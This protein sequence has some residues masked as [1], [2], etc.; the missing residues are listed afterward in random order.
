MRFNNIKLPEEIRIAH[1]QDR[2]VVFAGAGLSVPPPSKLPLFNGLVSKICG[3]KPV[4]E[5]R[6]DRILGKMKRAG[7]DVHSAAAGILFGKHTRPTQLHGEILRLFGKPERVRIVTT[8]FDDHFSTKS[9]EIFRLNRPQEYYAP[10]LP[11][12]D[13]FAGIVYLHGSARVDSRALVLTDRDF[14]I[15]YLTRGWAK[16]F[17][18]D[19]FS[20]YTVLFIGYSHNDVTTTYLAR[21]LSQSEVKPRWTMIPSNIKPEGRENWEHLEIKVIEYPVDTTNTSNEHQSLTDF[22]SEWAVHAGES[23]F[24]RAKRIKAIARSL[25]P[26]NET[27][28]EYLS[29]TLNHERLAQELCGNLK[30]PAWVGWLHDNGFFD[31]CFDDDTSNSSNASIDHH[32][33]IASWLCNFVRSRFPLL[34]LNLI[35]TH[36]QRLSPRFCRQLAHSLWTEKS[37]VPDKHFSEW[38]SILLA[39]GREAVPVEHFAYLLLK[40]RLPDH[41]GVALQLFDLLLTPRIRVEKGLDWSDEKQINSPL[42]IKVAYAVEWPCKDNHNISKAW[43]DVFQPHLTVIAEPLAQ[44]IANHFTQAHW[45][46]RGVKSAS[47]QYDPLSFSWSSIAQHDQNRHRLGECLATNVEILRE[48]F[49]HW[50]QTDPPRARMQLDIWWK[51]GIPLLRRFAAFAMSVDHQYSSDDRINWLLDHDLVFQSGMK[52]EVFDVLASAYSTA[53]MSIR[54]RLLQRI[55]RGYREPG[56]KNRR[57]ESIAYEQFNVLVWLRRS[58]PTCELIS[59]S[60]D[61]IRAA[62]P[63]FGE[64]EHPNFDI[65]HYDARVMDPAEGVDID[66]VISEPPEHFLNH[67]IANVSGDARRDLWSIAQNLPAFFKRDKSWGKG[68]V[69]ALSR[70][71]SLGDELWQPVFHAWREAIKTE[72]EWDWILTE[73]EKLPRSYAIYCG[74][75]YLIANGLWAK[76]T[77]LSNSIIDRAAL[78]MDLAWEICSCR[79]EPLDDNYRDWLTAAI[80][81]VGGWIGEFWRHYCGHLRNR[82]GEKWQ[83]IPFALR[84]KIEEAISGTNGV[85]IYA[86][87]A[88]TPWLGYFYTW[89]RDFSVKHLMPLLDWQR[90]SIVAQ[91]T[92][93]VLLDYNRGTSFELEELLIPYYQQFAERVLTMLKDATEKSDQFSSHALQ[94]LGYSL[95]GLATHVIP[96]PVESGFFRDFL[97]L[98]PDNV[99]SALAIGI[100]QQLQRF[101]DVRRKQIWDTWLRRYVDLRR[102]GV[103][104]A[105]SFSEA[106]YMLEWCLYLGPVFAE[107]VDSIAILPQKDVNAFGII[108]TLLKSSVL[109]TFP[110]HCCRLVIAALR[111]EDFPHLHPDLL[112]LHKN[113]KDAIAGTL[114]LQALEELLYLRGW[115]KK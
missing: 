6:E 69:E 30:H 51:S 23:L 110:L 76:D 80:N 102:I 42:P 90:D 101:D 107:A 68:F 5:G 38:V 94:N 88:L 96:N 45:L 115:N 28:S 64:R 100:M 7:T 61:K 89:D 87:I 97:P 35:Q 43:C 111:A 67:I 79:S 65:W 77:V 18:V 46:L 1:E 84:V 12:G 55:D 29:Y 58:A 40:C 60:I 78:H 113:F 36:K 26:E 31:L 106:K 2:L 14:G 54:R 49:L 70:Q 75:A 98:L 62:F 82:S 8:N 19:L 53:S 3:E 81:H 57:P 32:G 105:L 104:V 72:E 9:K 86:R 15:A 56:F 34:L 108:S 17:L 33:V 21:G 16:T 52:K 93:S 10:A 114:E 20:K 103:P 22:F 50:A 11:L 4:Q 112:T 27:I 74:V 83:G 73:I 95:S 24:A 44:I 41:L 99:R 37:K 66:K 13:N 71:T 48:I 85:A 25:P 92:W 63:H 59:P 91:Q 39:K 47:D 109:D